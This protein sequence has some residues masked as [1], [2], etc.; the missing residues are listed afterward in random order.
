MNLNE[1][2]LIWAQENISEN[3]VEASVNLRIER[4]YDP[5]FGGG[6]LE[7]IHEVQYRI[8]DM[9]SKKY[10]G[11][12]TMEIGYFELLNDLLEIA[13]RNNE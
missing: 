8:P 3:V 13:G 11:P 6:D 12:Y 1:A 7:L 5:T 9:G 4:Q 2:L 10:Y